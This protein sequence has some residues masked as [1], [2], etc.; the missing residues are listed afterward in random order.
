MLNEHKN[1]LEL[2][3]EAEKE[4]R[5]IYDG[6][7]TG[8]ENTYRS[9]RQASG[10]LQ[11]RVKSYEQLRKSEI[12]KAQSE[13]A[14]AAKEKAEKAAEVAKAEQEK[15]DAAK[16]NSQQEKTEGTEGSGN[17]VPAP[18][19]AQPP[20]QAPVEQARPQRRPQEPQQP[21]PN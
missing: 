12:A 20:R 13:K 19:A 9:L 7:A 18:S 2:V 10:F 4:A 14:Q 21:K 3:Q 1:L 15:A 11:E 17:I 16:A 5:R 6:G 8:I